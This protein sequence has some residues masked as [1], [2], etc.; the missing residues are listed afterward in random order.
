MAY[1]V[2]LNTS[3]TRRANAIAFDVR[4]KGRIKT[5]HGKPVKDA[6]GRPIRIPGQCKSVKGIGWYIEEY[7]IAQISMNLTK[8]SD[9]TLHEAYEACWASANRRGVRVTGSELI[10][11][12]PKQV[13]IDAGIYYLK[14]Q[15]RSVGIPER[16]IINIAVKSMGL[17]ELKPFDPDKKIIEYVMADKDPNALAHLSVTDFIDLTSSEQPAPGGGSV[18][19]AVA[20]M[21]IALGGMVANLSA[22]KRG[23][24]DRWELFSDWAA[25]AEQLK[26]SLVKLIDKDTQAFNK[27]IDAFRMPKDSPEEK[28][29]RDQAIQDA[30]KHAMLVPFQILEKSVASF[31]ILKEMILIG[32]PNSITDAGVGVLCARAAAHGA[33]LNVQVN[34]KDLK[35]Q[36]FKNQLLAEGL[37]LLERADT[38]EAELLRQVK[39]TVLG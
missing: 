11:L 13:M 26:R 25:R 23:W 24:D 10:G 30:T 38:L 34:A 36:A 37:L 18:A 4:E 1:N 9:T 31:E 16:A 22:H 27:I 21:G 12:V 39:N 3:S 5:K 7:G 14:L 33:Y 19:A 29:T 8:L 15:N 17:D 20:S 32:N 35:D 2:N 28:S 6:S